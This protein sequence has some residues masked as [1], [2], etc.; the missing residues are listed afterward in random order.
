MLFD[1]IITLP[2]HFQIG[3]DMSFNT[4]GNLDTDL[5]SYSQ[6]FN[7]NIHCV[8]DFFNEKLRLKFAVNNLFNTSREKWSKNTNNIILNKW[9]DA[10]RCTF[11]FTASYQINPSKNKYRGEKSTTELNRL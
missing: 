2:K 11:I 8:K 7:C 5:A 4:C 3:V 1:N 10:N 6:N 9:N